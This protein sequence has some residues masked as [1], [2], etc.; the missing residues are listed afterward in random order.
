MRHIVVAIGVVVLALGVAGVVAPEVILQITKPL[1]TQPMLWV[2]GAVRVAAGLIMIAAARSSRLPTALRVLGVFILLAGIATPL[3]GVE[4]SR[5]LVDWWAAKG[6]MVMRATMGV[7]VAFG[8][9]LIY[10][11]GPGKA[12]GQRI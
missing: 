4:H 5:A 6:P 1:V 7:A 3:T 9:F 12:P 10:A 8:A 2:I 11:A